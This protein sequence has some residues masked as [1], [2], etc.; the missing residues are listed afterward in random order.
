[1]SYKQQMTT[2]IISLISKN[3]GISSP[4]L[5]FRH[6]GKLKVVRNSLYS[7]TLTILK[8]DLEIW[9]LVVGKFYSFQPL[10]QIKM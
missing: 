4:V 8:A 2:K 9:S 7:E 1:M 10:N 3:Q 5:A 6:T